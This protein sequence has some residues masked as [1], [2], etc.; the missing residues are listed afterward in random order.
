MKQPAIP[1]ESLRQFY[2]RTNQEVPADLLNDQNVDHFNV[3][4]SAAVVKKSPYNRRDYYKICLVNGKNTNS[5]LFYNGQEIIIDGSCLLFTNPSVACSIEN[6]SDKGDRFYCLFNSRFIEGIIRTD[7]QYSCALF[8]PNLPPVIKLTE[9]QRSKVTAYFTEMQSLLATDYSYKWEMIRNL[10]MLLIHEGIR[11]Q[12]T[13]SHHSWILNDRV[14]N[15][16]FQLLNQQFPVDSPEH[17]LKPMTPLS[18]AEQLHVHVNHLNSV[19]KKHTG[20]TTSAI[21]HERVVAEAKTLLRNTDWNI[22]EIAYALGFEYPSYFNKYFK[23]FTLQTPVNF[24]LN[25]Q[26]EATVHL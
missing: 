26:V 18:F 5:K 9:E 1:T 4:Y 2:E 17:P 20:K 14:M 25:K 24:R 8:N 21:I 7:I 10:V 23:Q 16:F 6:N 3:R 22:A 15:G 12:N 11:L 19:V 13:Q